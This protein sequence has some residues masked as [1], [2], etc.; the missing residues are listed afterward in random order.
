M[1]NSTVII[2]ITGLVFIST[3]LLNCKKSK[4]EAP[5]PQ[6]PNEQEQIT[7]LRVII[8][9]GSTVVDTFSFRDIDGPGGN[10]PTIETIRLLANKNYSARLLLLDQSKV[11]AQN[12]SNA[13]VKEKNEHQ[14]FF[15]PTSVDLTVLYNDSDDYGVPLGIE[16]LINTGAAS[17]GTLRVLLKHQPN[18]KPKTGN[19]NSSLGATDIDV[20]FDVVI[21]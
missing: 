21:Q 12:I 1:K 14:F 5:T 2:R 19:G 18:V 17:T 20:T 16:T 6:N 7:T 4:D 11:P 8:K 13:I 10:A 15:T 9:E 3:L